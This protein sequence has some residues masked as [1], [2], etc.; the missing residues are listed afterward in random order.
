VGL[1]HINRADAPGN[2]PSADT[3]ARDT[4]ALGR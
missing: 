4:E 1:K 2:E 3:P